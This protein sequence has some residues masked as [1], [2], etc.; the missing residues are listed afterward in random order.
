MKWNILA[1]IA[2]LVLG[3]FAF[4]GCNQKSE[5]TPTDTTKTDSSTSSKSSSMN[6]TTPG[7]KA[8]E[9]NPA[10]PVAFTNDK[11]QIVCPVMGTVIEDPKKAVG[12]E[13]YEGKR[14]YFCCDGCP[15]QFKA[16]PEKYKN[17]K[18]A[19]DAGAAKT[20]N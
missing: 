16:N 1:V 17:G 20:G 8:P 10:E 12:Y 15:S 4:T 6:T 2:A 14:Y 9:A 5:E 7:D 18:P 11:G 3:A 19:E 13:D